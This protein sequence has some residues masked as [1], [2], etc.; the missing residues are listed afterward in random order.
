MNEADDL[1]AALLPV[2]RAFEHFGVNYYVGGSVASSY[3]GATRSTLDVDV[4]AELHDDQ[5]SEFLSALGDQYYSS[6][7]AIRDAIK[8]RSCFNLIHYPTS[9]KV[10]VFISRGRAFD[11]SA[12][13]R[14]T[15]GQLGSDPAVCTPIATAEDVIISKLEWYRIGGETSERQWDDVSKVFRLLGETADRDY[16]RQSAESVGVADLL[17]RLCKLSGA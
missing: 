5:V 2:V 10:D 17:D 13:T 12:M 14:S 3:H 15:M 1:V 7:S 9:F 6:E 16:L 4:V 11:R 8:R